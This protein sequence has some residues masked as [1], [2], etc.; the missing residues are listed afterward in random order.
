MCDR[1][2]ILNH[3]QC[4]A[5][6]TV[7][8]VLASG[9]AA[10]LVVGVDE[11]ERAREVL[12]RAG[13]PATPEHEHLVVDLSGTDGARVSRAL[14]EAGLVSPRALTAPGRSGNGLSPAH[15]GD[16]SG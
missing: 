8:E 4:I 12:E 14:A 6:G 7:D 11:P 1:V 10:Q 13:I 3:G 16:T 15:E 9:G 5:Q 2:A